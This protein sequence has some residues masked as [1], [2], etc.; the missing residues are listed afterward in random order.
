MRYSSNCNTCSAFGAGACIGA[1]YTHQLQSPCKLE[2]FFGEQVHTITDVEYVPEV[3]DISGSVAAETANIFGD[4][5]KSLVTTII[6]GSDDVNAETAEWVTMI[7]VCVDEQRCNRLHV[8]PSFR[9]I[10]D[11]CDKQ[12]TPIG[13]R[14]LPDVQT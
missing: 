13:S 4:G 14:Q 7:P 8:F 1:V 2:R 10:G 11:G 6:T 3:V 12:S 5:K 9:S